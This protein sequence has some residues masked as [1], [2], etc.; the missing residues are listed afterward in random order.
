[1]LP[2]LPVLVR[3]LYNAIH[4]YQFSFEVLH[5]CFRMWLWFRISWTK[6]LAARRIWRKKGTDR[7]ICIPPIHSPLSSWLR[8]FSIYNTSEKCKTAFSL[9]KH[10]KCFPCTKDRRNHTEKH[11]Y[12]GNFGFVFGGKFSDGNHMFIV[13]TSFSKTWLRFQT[14]SIHTKM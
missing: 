11:T 8:G 2:S 9:W 12:T 5:F 10:I 13:T 4:I 6:I 14:F 1:M 7:R 3:N